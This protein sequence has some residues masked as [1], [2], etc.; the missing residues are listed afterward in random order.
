MSWVTTMAVW[1][2]QEDDL[3][4]HDEGARDPHPPAHAS[5]QLGGQEL[6][7][8]RHAHQSEKAVHAVGDLA[9]GHA[10]VL[11]EG[12]GDVL[13]HGERVEERGPLEDEARALAHGEH[14]LLAHALDP[15]AEKRD[16][17]SIGP[18]QSRGDS[19]EHRLARPAPTHDGQG[20]PFPELE[21]HAAQDLLL[22]EGFPHVAQLDERP[23]RGFHITRRAG[24]RAW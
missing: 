22:V 11:A 20:G 2:T 8:A 5:G 16:L 6:V 18:H 7:G 12:I 15:R 17:A 24:G 14:R 1:Q 3:R 19:E 10:R 23:A 13:E 4:L 21:A 9:Q